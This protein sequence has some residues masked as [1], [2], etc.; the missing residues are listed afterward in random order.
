MKKCKSECP[1]STFIKAIG[2]CTLEVL[3][4]ALNE[5]IQPIHVKTTSEY[6][7]GPRTQ[8]GQTFVGTSY[9]FFEGNSHIQYIHDVLVLLS[10]TMGPE[11]S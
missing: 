3:C 7:Y 10:T 11:H 1:V 6:H 8:L 9:N 2:L 5:T 4:T